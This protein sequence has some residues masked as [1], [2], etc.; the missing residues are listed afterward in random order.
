MFGESSHAS[1]TA[2]PDWA[3]TRRFV[4]GLGARASAADAVPIAAAAAAVHNSVVPTAVRIVR[5]PGCE[6]PGRDADG[7]RR[8]FALGF[9]CEH[10]A[11]SGTGLVPQPIFK[12]GEPS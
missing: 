4:G 9:G 1:D 2:P 12:I 10:A 5:L 11:W 3:V 6:T 7:V 8:W